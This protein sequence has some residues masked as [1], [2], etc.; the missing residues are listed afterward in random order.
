MKL[1]SLT[2]PS[3]FLLIP[4]LLASLPAEQSKKKPDKG[5][6]KLGTGIDYSSGSYGDSIDTK[7]LYVPADI[8]FTKGLFSAKVTVPWVQIEGPGSV[9]GAGDG[10]VVVGG[11]GGV[12][13]TESGLGDIWASLTYSVEQV[14]AQLF[15]LDLVGKVK[16]PTADEN[17]GLGTGEFDYTIQA[18]LFKPFGKFTPMATVA[19][20]IKGDPGGVNLENVFYLSV[21][22]DYRLN[23][24]VNFGATIDFQEA[25]SSASD[26][27][28]ELF[29]Y[30]GYRPAQDWLLTIYG[31]AGLS[32]GSPDAGGGL[33][34]KRSL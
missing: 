10:G 16:I 15:Y 30:V 18:D 29:G 4:G 8:S 1:K 21:G 33:Q 25:S 17:R 31:Y 2:L 20:K 14:P 19:Y 3:V 5:K 28:L 6:W 34:V 23:D 26:D 13:M 11:G 9:I 22:A 24:A 12:S 7:I 32:D 27:A